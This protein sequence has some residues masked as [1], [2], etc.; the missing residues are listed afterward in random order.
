VIA[1][2]KSRALPRLCLCVTL[3]GGMALNAQAMSVT[4]AI[5]KGQLS[6]TVGEIQYPKTKLSKALNSGLP[7]NISLWLTL[8]HN[9]EQVQAIHLNHQITYDLW[10]EV[11][12]V[13]SQSS[14]GVQSSHTVN[15]LEQLLQILSSMTL[16][17]I[18]PGRT[19]KAS[20]GYQ[21]KAQVIVNPVQID[22]IKKIQAWIASSNGHKKPSTVLAHKPVGLG[23]NASAVDFGVSATG[24]A[25]TG[26]R[27]QKLFDKILEQY[28]QSDEI[29]ALWH[30]QPVIVDV[31]LRP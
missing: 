30:S 4:P 5:N 22:R 11:Y 25:S 18:M 7:N 9:S 8:T 6:V 13:Q 16:D 31:K 17:N 2:L 21:L 12:L 26:P 1:R 27:F 23:A 10:D 28:T 20:S 14:T 15:S 19:I 29:P 24:V 3:L